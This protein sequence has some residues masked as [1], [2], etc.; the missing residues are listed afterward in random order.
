MNTKIL[1][2]KKR[3]ILISAI[4]IVSLVILIAI[5]VHTNDSAVE[6]A[7]TSAMPMS[8]ET[9]PFLYRAGVY[10][11]SLALKDNTLTL[12]LVLDRDHINSVRLLQLDESVTTMYPLMQPACEAIAEQ[13]VGGVAPSD[14]RFED[15]SKYTQK[16]LMQLINTTL[17]KA[18]GA[19]TLP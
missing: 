12:E 11:S 6:S 13:L 1:V 15:S 9:A 19:D 2:L 17:E 8:E 3:N 16:L 7:P 4:V 14:V 18:Q 5:L 10:T